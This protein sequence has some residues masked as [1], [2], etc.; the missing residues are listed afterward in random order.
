ML[1]LKSLT[2]VKNWS[3]KT[4]LLR[5]D[6]NVKLGADMRVDKSED[7][8]V[9]SALPTVSYLMERQAKVVILSHLGRPGGK[10][11]ADLS[12]EPVAR[13][14][15]VLLGRKVERLDDC[16]GDGVASHIKNM[17]PGQ[18]VML[19]NVRFHSGEEKDSKKFAQQLASLGDVY[20]ND[21]FAVSHHVGA[22]LSAITA[23]LPSYAG[24]LLQS[25]IKELTAVLDRPKRPLVVILG[26]AKIGSKLG[27]IS[28]LAKQADQVLIGGGL[29][30]NF[31]VAQGQ[32]IGKSFYEK[33]YIK[34]TKKIWHTSRKKISLPVD[35]TVDDVKTK[36]LEAVQKPVGSLRQSDRI[37]DIGTATVRNWSAVIKRAR[38]IIWN[39][40][41]GIVEER[42]SSHAS[43]ALTELVA[44][45]SKRECYSVVGGGETVWLIQQ[46]GLFDDFDYISTGGGAMIAFLEGDSF[47]VL[48]P[49]IKK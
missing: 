38:T 47:S 35:V 6:L 41:L 37:I 49:L 29:A 39:G 20:V 45:R 24:F 11:Q 7:F 28:R 14:L 23:Y 15:S 18:V 44:A 3:G 22:S 5:L 32:A 26:G 8:K 16:I 10:P 27:L 31:F 48:R 17:R 4:V 13:R 33:K 43:R 30:N 42:R 40:P 9:T 36:Q 1:K 21:A 19:E 34:E 2:Q 12:L 25:E 46:M